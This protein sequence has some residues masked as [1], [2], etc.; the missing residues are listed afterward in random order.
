M[1]RLEP[2]KPRRYD[3]ETRRKYNTVEDGEWEVLEEF[4]EMLA[5][6]GGN[7]PAD[8]IHRLR[9]E[10]HLM[11]TNV[12]VFTLATAVMSQVDLIQRL[13]LTRKVE[14]R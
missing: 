3:A 6:T 7:D 14:V 10:K 4:G 1:T 9:T 13:K 2:E 8:L 12:V 5:N 11:V